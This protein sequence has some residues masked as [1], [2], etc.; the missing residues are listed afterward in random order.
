ME[1]IDIGDK[2]Y[3][4]IKR[5]ESPDIEFVQ[6]LKDFY[7]E[8]YTDF[9]LIKTR[10]KNEYLMCRTIHNLTFVEEDNI[11][12][13]QIERGFLNMEISKDL[14]RELMKQ[15][16]DEMSEE[17]EILTSEINTTSDVTGYDGPLTAKIKKRKLSKPKNYKKED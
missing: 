6:K 17:E 5:F 3:H 1:I 11:Y 2:R 12:I 9:E 4:V 15:V 10:N 14:V 7:K 16:I 13:Q 8:I